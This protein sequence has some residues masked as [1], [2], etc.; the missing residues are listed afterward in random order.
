MLAVYICIP[1]GSIFNSCDDMLAVLSSDFG[2]HGG[3]VM[4]VAKVLNRMRKM[5]QALFISVAFA[6]QSVF[7][8][9][10]S[11]FAAASMGGV[12]TDVGAAFR[13]QTGHDVILVTAGSSTL[14]RQ[15]ENGAPADVFVS[16]NQA[17]VTYLEQA[18]IG[19]ARSRRDIANNALVLVTSDPDVAPLSHVSALELTA[20]DF[21]AMAMVDAI[22]AGIY[23]KAALGHFDRWDAFEPHVVQADNVRMALQFVA[24]GEA[25]YGIVYATDAI[26]EPRVRVIYTFPD[27]SHDPIVYPALQLSQT[28]AATDFMAFL[29][30]DAA[31]GIFMRHGFTIPQNDS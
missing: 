19:L 2:Y 29:A 11:V 15:I 5:M 28:Q 22:P 10:V 9:T 24:L 26:A 27:D 25:K 6:P 1:Y 20:D 14:A 21:V 16:A 13:E 8:D 7:A 3:D 30:T 18:G 12:L 23:G 31:Q 4:G 17:W